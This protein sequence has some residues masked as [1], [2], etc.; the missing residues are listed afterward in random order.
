[1]YEFTVN[2]MVRGYHV[3]QD[4]WEVNIGEILPCTREIGNRHDPYAVA[5]WK[6]GIVVGHVPRKISCICSV[7]IRRGGEIHCTVT[8]SRRYSADLAQG[9]MEIPCTL[10]FKITDKHESEKAHKLINSTLKTVEGNLG[11][12]NIITSARLEVKEEQKESS[13]ILCYD[14]STICNSQNAEMI[15]LSKCATDDL[16]TADDPPCK[17]IKLDFERIIMGEKLSDLDI[18]AAQRVLKQQ[19][20]NIHGLEST[21]YQMKERR[22]NEDQVKDK[23]QIIHCLQRQHW[24]VAT[25]VGCEANVVKV[26]DSMFH[27]VDHPTEKVIVN[28]FQC[29]DILPTIKIGRSQ[30]Q[31]GLNDCGIFAIAYATA[32]AFGAQP[33]KQNMTQDVM[34]AHLVNCLSNE[35]FSVFP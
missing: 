3:Y 34:R 1:M 4:V 13:P 14:S 20:P 27:S 17:K 5:V 22:L 18:N 19:F 11:N 15:D 35:K 28:L 8:N 29:T 31:K 25:T 33:E 10:T 26:Y 16:V 6:D 30:K 24:I 23:I 21:L 2:A 9:G 12:D 32:I 7:F